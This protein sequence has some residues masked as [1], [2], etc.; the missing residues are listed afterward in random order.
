MRRS[1]GTN[2]TQDFEP[3]RREVHGQEMKAGQPPHRLW[4]A[5]QQNDIPA[6]FKPGRLESF[7][8]PLDAGLVRAAPINDT[9]TLDAILLG[10]SGAW[11]RADGHGRESRNDLPPPHA[12]HEPSHDF[13]SAPHV[14]RPRRGGTKDTAS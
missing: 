13:G 8:Q 6:F 4:R 3:F 9:D 7:A 10:V 5:Q 12:S 11:P 1:F 2:L 14:P